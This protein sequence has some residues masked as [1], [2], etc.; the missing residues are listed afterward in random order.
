MRA[1]L[2]AEVMSIQGLAAEV[3]SIQNGGFVCRVVI[4]IQDGGIMLQDVTSSE[5]RRV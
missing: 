1:P 2:A 4:S 5:V 3:I